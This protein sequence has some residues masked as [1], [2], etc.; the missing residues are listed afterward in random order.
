MSC[1]ETL[2]CCIWKVAPQDHAVAGLCLLELMSV[3]TIRQEV[4]AQL[5]LPWLLS[6]SGSL[7]QCHAEADGPSAKK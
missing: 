4:V 1:L 7:L 5:A 3:A 2:T 6:F